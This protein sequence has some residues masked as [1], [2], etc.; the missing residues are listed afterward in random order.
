MLLNLIENKISIFQFRGIAAL[1]GP[2]EKTLAG[3]LANRPASVQRH[4]L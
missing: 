2:P 4:T 3:R 1:S